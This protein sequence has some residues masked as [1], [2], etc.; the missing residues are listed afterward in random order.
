M[1]SLGE[2]EQS[3]N[4]SGIAGLFF[5]LILIL[6]LTARRRAAGGI[7]LAAPSFAPLT[8]EAGHEVVAQLGTA[9]GELLTAEYRQRES[10]T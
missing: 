9:I 4:L 3:P 2:G 10:L 7:R 1:T 6:G 8:P 5:L